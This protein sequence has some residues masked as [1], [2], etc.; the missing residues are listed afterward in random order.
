MDTKVNVIE[1][2]NLHGD[3]E[4]T[5]HKKYPNESQDA[6]RHDQQAETHPEEKLTK[7]KV[8]SAQIRDKQ[9]QQDKRK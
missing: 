4:M 1:K 7:N 5:H 6:R 2:F 8:K 9:S 3:N